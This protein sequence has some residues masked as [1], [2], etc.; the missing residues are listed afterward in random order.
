ML[1]LVW[2]VASACNQVY[3]LDPTTLAPTPPDLDGDGVDDDDD[4]CRQVM[5]P[6]QRD[7]DGDG[8]GDA[9]DLCVDVATTINHDEDADTHGDACDLCPGEPNFQSDQEGDGVG[10]DCDN[11]AATRNALALFDPFTT[12]DAAWQPTS[13]S[14]V[15]TGDAAVPTVADTR[16]RHLNV[17]VTGD[18]NMWLRIGLS[19]GEKWTNDRFGFELVDTTSGA[20]VAGCMITCNAG[21]CGLRRFPETVDV[22]APVTPTPAETLV[23]NHAL[24]VSACVF[25]NIV[26]SDTRIPFGSAQ[27]VL[28]GSPKVQV[29]YVAVW[30]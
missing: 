22:S 9:C 29:R 18:R 24:T 15:S 28:V 30:Q 25:G 21:T 11:D 8:F 1:P 3:G 19:S 7:A 13:A 14:W 17:T 5:N 2:F 12:I 6:D 4:N 27:L 26:D 10:D 20:V 23:F 16:L